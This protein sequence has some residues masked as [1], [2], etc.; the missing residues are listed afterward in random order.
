MTTGD[1][2]RSARIKHGLSLRA[3]AAKAGMYTSTL[4]RIEKGKQEARADQLARLAEA[5]D[6]T[7]GDFFAGEASAS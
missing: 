5:L 2:V 4:H 6:G 7:V 1:L 3:L